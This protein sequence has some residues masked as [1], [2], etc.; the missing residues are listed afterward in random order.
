MIIGVPKEVITSFWQHGKLAG[1]FGS[2]VNVLI[3][4][5]EE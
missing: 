2:F 5:I 4:N 1:D 3:E